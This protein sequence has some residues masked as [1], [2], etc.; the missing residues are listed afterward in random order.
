VIDG[1][2][3]DFLLEPLRH[4]RGSL[5]MFAPLDFQ[6][7][8]M[9]GDAAAALSSRAVIDERVHP[10]DQVIGGQTA[11]QSRASGQASGRRRRRRPQGRGASAA[12]ARS[13]GGAF[14]ESG[15]VLLP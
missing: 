15:S 3:K 9:R 4:F 5:G 2:G 14:L 13:F 1:R 12:Q 11:F 6:F 8:M 7:Q 10:L